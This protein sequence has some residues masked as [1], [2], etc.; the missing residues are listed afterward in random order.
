MDCLIDVASQEILAIAYNHLHET[1]VPSMLDNFNRLDKDI[2]EVAQWAGKHDNLRIEFELTSKC[3]KCGQDKRLPPALV[4]FAFNCGPLI[5][6][7]CKQ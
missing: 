4:V 5:A 6:I 3:T 7:D 1:I 2:V